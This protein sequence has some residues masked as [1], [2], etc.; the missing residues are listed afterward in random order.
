MD[1][2]EK[3]TVSC[4]GVKEQTTFLLIFVTIGPGDENTAS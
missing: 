2:R 1:N 3:R 4:L